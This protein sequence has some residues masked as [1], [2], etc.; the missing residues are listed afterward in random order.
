MCHNWVHS[1]ILLRHVRLI[2]PNPSWSLPNP[3][4]Y[5]ALNVWLLTPST[6]TGAG[7]LHSFCPVTRDMG[8]PILFL[9]NL[10]GMY[11]SYGEN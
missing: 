1:D 5:S 8:L 11:V 9:D 3:R 2:S 10:H 4:F 7:I 6:H